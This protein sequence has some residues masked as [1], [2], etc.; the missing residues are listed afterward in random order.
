MGTGFAP[1]ALKA[2]INV[3]NS[4]TLIFN[5]FKSSRLKTGNLVVVKCLVPANHPGR[6]LIE[7]VSANPLL[8]L[9]LLSHQ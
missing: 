7:D 6:I 5:P 9:H 2:S 4:G 3:L 1:K 8:I